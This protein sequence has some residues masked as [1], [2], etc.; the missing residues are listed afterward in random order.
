MCLHCKADSATPAGSGSDETPG[1]AAVTAAD[2]EVNG[3][4][5]KM[6]M[7]KNCTSYLV[8]PV[9]WLKFW[10]SHM[11]PVSFSMNNLKSL[12]RR[13][14]REVT[15]DELLKLLEFAVGIESAQAISPDERQ[16]GVLLQRLLDTNASM[17]RKGRDLVIPPDWATDGEYLLQHDGDTTY[18]V[19]RFSQSRVD[20]ADFIEDETLLT[21]NGTMQIDNNWS[22]LRATLKRADGLFLFRCSALLSGLTKSST[23]V[24]VQ[25]GANVSCLAPP[26]LPPSATP[27]RRVPA[28]SHLAASAR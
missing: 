13:G 15:R 23:P 1:V 18:L 20:L 19:H 26:V 14:S 16:P 10:L 3:D 22:E 6:P 25:R 28:Q 7:E 11:E 2:P 4:L 17:G 5:S 24:K 21:S 27:P 12:V 8:A 9:K